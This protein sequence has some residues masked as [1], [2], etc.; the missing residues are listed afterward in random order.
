VMNYRYQMTGV[1]RNGT[2]GN[3]DYQR[4][5]LPTLNENSLSEVSGVGGGALV[6]GYQTIY[7]CPRGGTPLT[8]NASAAINWN[9]DNDSTDSGVSSNSN[10]DSTKGDLTS[11]SDWDTLIFNGGG[12]IG[13]GE[14]TEVLK[15]KAKKNFKFLGEEELTEEKW[16]NMAAPGQI[17][18]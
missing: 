9:C 1:Y 15:E 13:S 5:N 10:G 11:V 7:V 6:S 18:K 16:K 14:S 2:W 4:F 17:K 12:V 3:Y 8:V